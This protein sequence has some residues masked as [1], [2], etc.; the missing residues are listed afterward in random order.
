MLDLADAEWK[1]RWGASPAG[2]DFQAI[3]GAML[4]LNGE[5]ATGDWLKAL[6]S[7][8]PAYRGN[9]K[10]MRGVKSARSRARVIYH[11]YYFGDQAKTGENCDK[12]ALHYFGNQDPGA[13]VSVSGGGVL[14][15]SKQQEAAQAFLKWITG[16]GARRSCATAHL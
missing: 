10:A 6:K 4:E 15:S 3:V 12:L 8:A 7:N 16:K 2:A 5:E 14:A 1:G 9:N 13:F 11:Y